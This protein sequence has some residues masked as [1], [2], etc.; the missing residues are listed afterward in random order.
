MARV[1]QRNSVA[2]EGI[3]AGTVD[4]RRRMSDHV[5]YGLLVYTALQI[6]VTMGALRSQG[7][8]LLP[9]MALVVLVG[10]II[11]ACR[12]FERRW[13]RLD[14]RQAR[15]PVMAD[16]F[17]R[18]RNLFWVLAIGLPFLLTGMFKGLALLFG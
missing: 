7:R 5:A 2:S 13:N 1:W 14:D 10:A 6:F 9:Y 12:M 16:Q 4:W 11:P 17:R 8:S 15:D 3:S 18:D